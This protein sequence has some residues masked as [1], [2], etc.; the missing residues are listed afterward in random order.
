MRKPANP[1]L[2]LYFCAFCENRTMRATRVS[3]AAIVE[4]AGTV[5]YTYDY[6]CPESDRDEH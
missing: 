2:V 4:E 3:L 1:G 5:R 6:C